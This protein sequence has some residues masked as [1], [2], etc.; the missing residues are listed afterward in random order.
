MKYYLMILLTV[1]LSN[2]NT[3]KNS[4]NTGA[5]SAEITTQEKKNN[6]YYITT[7]NKK[8]VSKEKL[9]ITI[10][11][12]AFL[13]SGYSGCNTFSC[14]YTI[15]DNQITTS[16]PITTKRFC[17][18]KIALENEFLKTISNIKN[19]DTLDTKML[20]TGNNTHEI[21]GI[22]KND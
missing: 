1:T 2:T 9:Y 19:I 14:K 5:E 6:T 8:D 21:I 12:D 11:P 15:T 20:L 3:C 22:I 18:E 13:I 17:N 10:D 7:L 16:I 4:T